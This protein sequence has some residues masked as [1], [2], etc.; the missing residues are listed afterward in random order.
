M[1]ILAD[2]R[3]IKGNLLRTGGIT[4]IPIPKTMSP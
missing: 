3:R 2:G 4:E 1:A